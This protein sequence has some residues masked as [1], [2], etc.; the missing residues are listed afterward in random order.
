MQRSSVVVSTNEST[1]L[2]ALPDM[3]LGLLL[4]LLLVLLELLLLLLELLALFAAAALQ[5][6]PG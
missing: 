2:S 3:V 5:R 4:L 1:V 6:F